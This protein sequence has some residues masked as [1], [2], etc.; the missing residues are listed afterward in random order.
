[1][2]EEKLKVA[3]KAPNAYRM[4]RKVLSDLFTPGELKLCTCVPSK[5]GSKVIREQADATKLNYLLGTCNILPYLV[6]LYQGDRSFSQ[7]FLPLI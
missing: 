5:P 1:M 3:A 2:P 4:A 6:S 7:M